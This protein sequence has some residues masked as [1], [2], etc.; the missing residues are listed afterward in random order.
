MKLSKWALIVAVVFA[1]AF[2]MYAHRRTHEI[3]PV[4]SQNWNP[5]TGIEVAY[6][7]DSLS[8]DMVRTHN[9]FIDGMRLITS[10]RQNAITGI[11]DDPANPVSLFERLQAIAPVKLTN[12][13]RPGAHIYVR[14]LFNDPHRFARWLLNIPSFHDQV[15]SLLSRQSIP[16][17]VI[18]WTGHMEPLNWND[19]RHAMEDRKFPDITEPFALRKKIVWDFMT[20]YQAEVRRIV[21]AASEKSTPT[22]LILYGL[23]NWNE[24]NRLS[25]EIQMRKKSGLPGYT[26]A[27]ERT[28]TGEAFELWNQLNTE[29]EKFAKT[30]KYEA[31]TAP[32]RVYFKD[33]M[34]FATFT[35]ADI[36]DDGIHPL[37][38]GQRKLSEALY[39]GLREALEDRKSPR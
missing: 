33:E 26:A 24:T 9:S 10:G 27:K 8:T 21:K 25:E 1:A 29:I 38:S 36:A 30:L 31:T 15:D 17:F 4:T 2:I 11:S 35:L 13:S 3:V 6:I 32:V 19:F 23:F 14:E 39:S 22:F 20:H 12:Y 18:V 7:G 16:E 34:Q 28:H 37:T 5:Y